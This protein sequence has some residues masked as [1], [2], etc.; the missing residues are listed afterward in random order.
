MVNR[1]IRS[2]LNRSPPKPTL[3]ITYDGL[4]D[5]L[6]A[7]QI[8]PY[9]Q[10]ISAHR[11]KLYVLSFEKDERLRSE[12]GDL[13][14]DLAKSEIKW[15]VLRFTRRLGV[16]GKAWDLLR[17]YLAS[18]FIVVCSRPAFIHARGH[19][20]AQVG[21]LLK[22]LFGLKLIF[23]FRGLWVDERVDKGSW[24]LAYSQHRWQY[25]YF[26]RV[27]RKLLRNADQ[28]VVLTEAVVPEVYRLGASPSLA[29]TVIPCCAN[30]DHFPLV[31]SHRRGQAREVF[32]IP[33][34]AS[35]LG[36]LGST[37]LMYRIDRL[38][39]LFEIAID[40]QDVYLLFVTP[41]VSSLRSLMIEHLPTALHERVHVVSA[42][43]SQVP[44]FIAAMD[45]LVSFI[46]PSYARIAASPTKLAECFAAGIPVIC[47]SGVGDVEEQVRALR[48]GLVV[49]LNS[50]A[51]LI[52]A[53]VALED[54]T[55]M[56]GARLRAEARKVLGLE[57]AAMRYQ[58]V[59]AGLD[60]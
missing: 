13:K 60:R 31:T 6:G 32:D 20:A 42:S 14:D 40:F 55:K 15:T 2:I 11:Q 49:D 19:S 10:E 33:K 54:I 58:A 43:R 4:L 29:V 7:S 41:D 28:L 34:D 56:G 52:A 37:G 9:L 8:V 5:P 25:R 27:E 1:V 22:Q 39:R 23:D 47:N 18:L 3:F 53:A 57:V 26:K 48:A 17:M 51:D 44:H 46:Q 36:Y 12:Y 21:L 24:N 35:V 45:V 59:Y 30:F 38:F 50:D 16:V